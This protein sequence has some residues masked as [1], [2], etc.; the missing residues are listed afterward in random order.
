MVAPNPL[1]RGG[2]SWKKFNATVINDIWPEV[3][4]FTLVAVM[5]CL[6]S[7]L[8]SVNLGISNALLTVL[9]TVLGLVI[10]F[11]T[12]SAY[13]RYQDGRKMWTAI[14]VASK[15]LTQ[16][17][18]IHAQSDRSGIEAL[19]NQTDIE[20]AV[21]K[22]TMINLIQAFSVAV[23]HFLRDEPGMYYE[24]LYPLICFLPRHVNTHL[25]HEKLPLWHSH[26]GFEEAATQVET[27]QQESLNGL[28]IDSTG[29]LGSW[30]SRGRRSRRSTFDPESVLPRVGSEHPLKPA[31]NPPETRITDYIPLFRVFRWLG[32]VI[33]RRTRSQSELG[34]KRLRKRGQGIDLVE[35]HIP[36]EIL[37]VLSNYSAFLMKHSLIQPAIASGITAN[38]ALLQDTLSNLERTC[39]TPLPFAYQAHLRMSLWL[40]L[41]FLPF[42]IY[43]LFGYITIPGTCFASFLLLGFLEIGQEIE[44]PFNYDLNDLDLDYFCLSLQR[45]LHQI[46]AY[47]NP[48]PCDFLYTNL[49][50]PFAPADRRGADELC[51]M[52]REYRYPDETSEA[53][54][55]SIKRTLIHSWRDVDLKTRHIR[56]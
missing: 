50:Q 30:P 17:I 46:T 18:W 9:G 24:D 54:M 14:G 31:R 56:H 53:G 49:N 48:N 52:G 38:L 22:K 13:E 11:R 19:Q 35:S 40:Y 10:S 21:E 43:D 42:Q 3:F 23:K 32:Q 16:M 41:L 33:L 45:E 27:T 8:T 1:F 55:A 6:V 25:P 7:N 4:F 26:E 15:N 51:H 28:Q 44:N 5:V 2:W 36:L 39:N 34:G 47:N 12:S 20:V 37:L 29:K